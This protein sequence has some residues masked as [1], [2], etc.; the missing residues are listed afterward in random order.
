MH[1]VD[2]ESLPWAPG[3][4]RC[5]WVHLQDPQPLQITKR[6]LARAFSTAIILSQ[7]VMG[8]TTLHHGGERGGG[9]SILCIM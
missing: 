5:F 2:W 9:G 4:S 3:R 8:R 6:H 7:H 1:I